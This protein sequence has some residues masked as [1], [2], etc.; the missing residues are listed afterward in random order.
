MVSFAGDAV[1]VVWPCHSKAQLPSAALQAVACCQRM[2]A[3]ELLQQFPVTA[4]DQSQLKLSYHVGVGMGSMTGLVV[5]HGNVW[6]YVA[7]GEAVW[8][9]NTMCTL[10][11][12]GEFVLSP[13][14][15]EVCRVAG[16]RHGDGTQSAGA[17]TG[18]AG[19]GCGRD[20]E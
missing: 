10:G 9:C 16:E 4:P 8:Q 6:R 13:E 2:R 12:H 1:L 7:M 17:A 19:Q 18:G 5:G 11:S 20:E 14:V 3:D 15:Y